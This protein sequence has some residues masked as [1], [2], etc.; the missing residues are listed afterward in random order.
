W[1]DFLPFYHMG[2]RVN[3]KIIDAVAFNYWIINGTQQTEPFNGFKDQFFGLTLTPN[4]NINWNINYYLGQEHP[5][6][7]FFP[8]GGAPPNSPTFQG[9]PFQPIPNAPNGRLHI[10]DSYITWQSTP[11]LAFVL[12]GD[13]VNERLLKNSAPSTVWGGAA[14]AQ[15]RFTPKDALALRVEYLGD[16]GGVYTGETPAPTETPPAAGPQLPSG[17]LRQRPLRRAFSDQAGLFVAT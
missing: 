4:K 6:V 15:Y 10:F 8:F 1:F 9:L 3:Y 14:Y 2:A 7:V 11:K 12:E 16:H 17:F 13:Y 5:D